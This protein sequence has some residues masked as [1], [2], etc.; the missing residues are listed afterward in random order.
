MII[1]TIPFVTN[2]SRQQIDNYLAEHNGKVISQDGIYFKI[3]LPSA[4]DFFF[5]GANLTLMAID[6]KIET[7]KKLKKS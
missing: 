7:D 1:E 2:V 6:N 3:Q 5:F 4:S